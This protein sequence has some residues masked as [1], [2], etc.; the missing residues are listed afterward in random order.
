MTLVLRIE[1]STDGTRVTVADVAAH[2]SLAAASERHRPTT[3][4][5]DVDRWIDSATCATRA[6]LDSLAAVGPT[7]SDLRAVEIHTEAIGGLVVLDAAGAPVHEA[8]LG[9]HVE[10][11]A[12]ADW[13]VGRIDGGAES[14][15]A[16]TGVLPAIGSTVSLMS[17]LHRTD[18]SAWEAM[19]RCTLPIGLFAERLG[20]RPAVGVRDAVGTAVADRRTGTTWCTELLRIVDDER[21]WSTTMPDIVDTATPVGVLD[22]A[23]AG[24]LGV[25]AGL[26]LHMGSTLRT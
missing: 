22:E 6:A 14:W 12:D 11:G 18:A 24:A 7:S 15:L 2:T 25:P 8:L 16:A 23:V 20:A 5:R 21:D 10:S 13:L 4:G 26:P 3:S 9:T 19:A 1:W 17:W